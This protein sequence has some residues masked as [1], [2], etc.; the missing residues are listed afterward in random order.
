MNL[1]ELMF[2]A[3]TLGV[4]VGLGT[5]LSHKFGFVGFLGGFIGAFVILV[6]LLGGLR[7]LF[8][9]VSR[10]QQQGKMKKKKSS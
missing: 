10:K 5:A 8:N 6:L 2:F 7:F 4:G 9:F 3:L 1:C